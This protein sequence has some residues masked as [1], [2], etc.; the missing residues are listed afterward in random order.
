MKDFI[1]CGI[2]SSIIGYVIVILLGYG[3]LSGVGY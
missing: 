2:P 3:I 1:L